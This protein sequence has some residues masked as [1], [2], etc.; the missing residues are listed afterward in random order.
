MHKIQFINQELDKNINLKYPPIWDILQKN[1]ISVG[2]F[3]SLQSFPPI[4]SN[5]V[6]FY[7]PDT[8]SPEFNSYPKELE[9][10]Q[11]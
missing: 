10:F 5:C 8:F 11:R 4:K 2:V 3:G 7:L 1:K 9:D 6:K